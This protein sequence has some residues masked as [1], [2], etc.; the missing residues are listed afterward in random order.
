MAIFYKIYKQ[1]TNFNC[2]TTDSYRARAKTTA[3]YNSNDIAK[4]I[5]QRSALTAGD[6]ASVLIN[7]S[8]IVCELLDDGC[9]VSLGELGS[10]RASLRSKAV[11]DPGDFDT[12]LHI[13]RANIVF[14]PS[15]RLKQMLK[16]CKYKRV[17]R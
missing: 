16:S 3:H 9:K 1:K 7:Y 15:K 13:Q 10:L 14:T 4:M 2:T 6:V 12:R 8:E 11:A 5:A 17:N